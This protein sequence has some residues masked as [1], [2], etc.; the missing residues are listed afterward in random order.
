VFGNGVT[1]A[2][3]GPDQPPPSLRSGS[4]LHVVA[5]DIVAREIDISV[6]G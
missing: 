2:R 5:R 6:T 3:H 4:Q 1:F